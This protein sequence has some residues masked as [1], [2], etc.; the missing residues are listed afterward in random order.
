MTLAG[1]EAIIADISYADWTFRSG[2]L[3]NGFFVQVEF[4]AEDCEH[5]HIRH[6]I[7]SGRKWYIS[8]HSTVDEVG[9][10]CLKTVLTALEHEAREQFTYK[11]MATF[12]P[13]TPIEKLVEVARERALRS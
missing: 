1:I 8:A 11:G 9:Q 12:Q 5:Q 13:H 10:T 2:K 7:W 3:G 4:W 6:R